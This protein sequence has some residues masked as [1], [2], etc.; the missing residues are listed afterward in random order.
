MVDDCWRQNLSIAKFCPN[1]KKLRVIFNNGEID[2]L[3]DIFNSSRYLERIEIGCGGLYLDEKEV[4]EVVV[5]NSPKNFCELKIFN[6]SSDSVLVPEDLESFFMSWKNRTP[7]KSLSLTI[8]KNGWVYRSSLEMDE[9]N[10]KIVEIYKN[11]GVIKKFE[12][13][14]LLKD[15]DDEFPSSL[16]YYS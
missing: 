16:S 13:K 14:N 7:S 4:L 8:I 2:I 12:T 6:R 1:L 11:L 3:K 5:M 10:M 15:D 9:N